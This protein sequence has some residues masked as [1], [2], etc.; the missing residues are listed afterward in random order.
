M[1][2]LVT[3]RRG[4]GEGP[5]RTPAYLR[6]RGVTSWVV[7]GGPSGRP[8]AALAAP[9]C[10]CCARCCCSLLLLLLLAAAAVCLLLLLLVA[11]AV[12]AAAAATAVVA[13][14][15]RH[16]VLLCICVTS[17]IVS[18]HVPGVV[19]GARTRETRDHR[20]SKGCFHTPMAA[21]VIHP[22]LLVLVRLLSALPSA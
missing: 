8:P 4:V 6:G 9:R 22:L 20:A 11:A 10:S 17:T 5:L 15:L 12:A 19:S 13:R 14:C 16:C 21:G 3:F 7:R 1:R 2:R 18:I